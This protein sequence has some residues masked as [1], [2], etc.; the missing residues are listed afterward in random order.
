MVSDLHIGATWREL[1]RQHAER[2]AIVDERGAWTF[3]QLQSRITRFGNA[4]R[5][6]PLAKGDRVALLI[7]DI[8][9]YLEA[10]YAIMSAG[11]VRVP[12]DPRLTRPDLAALLRFSDATALV[13]H[14]SFADKTDG[15]LD[16]VESLTKRCWNEHPSSRCRTATAKSSPASISAAAPPGHPKPSC[17]GIETW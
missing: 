2:I 12:L 9:E 6:L 16:E 3:R 14:G 11:F 17:C 10:D 13:A 4:L 5:A 7:P 1:A 8:R 15:L